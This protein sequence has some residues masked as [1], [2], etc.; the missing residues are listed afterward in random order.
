M[1][2][3]LAFSPDGR[4]LASAIQNMI[5]LWDPVAEESSS[6]CTRHTD[7]IESLSFSPDCRILT[8]GSK[9]GNIWLWGL[10]NVAIS[11]VLVGHTAGVDS[12]TFSPDRMMLASVST[13]TTIILWNLVTGKP[14]RSLQIGVHLRHLKFSDNMKFLLTDRGPIDIPTPAA[15]TPSGESSIRNIFVHEQWIS[16]AGRNILWLPVD[17]RAQFVEVN[18]NVVALGCGTGGMTRLE[19]DLDLLGQA[20]EGWYENQISS[21]PIQQ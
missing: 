20:M 21:P 19:F 11:S 6:F 10:K 1:G 18:R 9:D 8:S 3:A 13:D 2:V 5:A 14:L 4:L 7:A 17:I 12:M 15:D 16:V